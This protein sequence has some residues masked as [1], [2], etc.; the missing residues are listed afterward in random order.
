MWVFSVM[1]AYL[2]TLIGMRLYESAPRAVKPRSEWG[3]RAARPF[4]FHNLL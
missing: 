2:C 1:T 4:P 3:R